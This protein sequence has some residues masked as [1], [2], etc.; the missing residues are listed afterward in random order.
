MCVF[1]LQE[2]YKLF[3]L[4]VW[5][6]YICRYGRVLQCCCIVLQCTA[7][8]YYCNM[9]QSDLTHLYMQVLP[10]DTAV[11]ARALCDTPKN[12]TATHCNALQRTATN[13]NALQRTSTRYGT[14][15]QHCNTRQPV[16]ELAMTHR[17]I[18]GHPVHCNTLQHTATHCNTL[19]HTATILQHTVAH[20][21]TLQQYCNNTATH[22]MQSLLSLTYDHTATHYN[23]TAIHYKTLQHT[24][25][26]ATHCMQVQKHAHAVAAVADVWSHCNTLQQN[27]NNTATTLQQCCNNSATTLQQHCSN[28]AIHTC[29]C[30]HRWRVKRTNRC[31]NATLSRPIC[32]CWFSA[33]LAT[34]GVTKPY[35]NPKP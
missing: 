34:T 28:T 21:N 5:I 3:L 2:W 35:S 19:Q 25:T 16:L 27:C 20:W 7:E 18:T 4:V 15:Q 10:C 8:Q 11:C 9:L 6:V 24:A 30:Y 22:Y 33:S 1:S 31:C 17:C 13:C 32:G 29:S 12:H 14:P 26:T 23:N